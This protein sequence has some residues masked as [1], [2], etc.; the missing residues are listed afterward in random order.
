MK[1]LA[2]TMLAASLATLAVA[3]AAAEP[4]HLTIDA[5]DI[6]VTS[7]AGAERLAQ[8]IE[9]KV[10]QACERPFMRDLVA[11]RGYQNCVASARDVTNETLGLAGTETAG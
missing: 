6:D 10:E 4:V 7:P 5:S 1:F 11:M 9:A 3:P 8:R 2:S